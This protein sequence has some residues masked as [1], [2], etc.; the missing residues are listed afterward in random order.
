MYCRKSH[1]DGYRVQLFS[2][3]MVGKKY[4]VLFSMLNSGDNGRYGDD[5]VELSSMFV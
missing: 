5:D 2:H 1:F 4:K 3:L